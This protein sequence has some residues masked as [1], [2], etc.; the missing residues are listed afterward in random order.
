M[1]QSC[2]ERN[3]VFIFDAGNETRSKEFSKTLK[4]MLP[5]MIKGKLEFEDCHFCRE[6]TQSEGKRKKFEER[7]GF[8]FLHENNRSLEGKTMNTESLE[9]LQMV[10][11][12]CISN[13]IPLVHYTGSGFFDGNNN[14]IGV[15]ESLRW[16]GMDKLHVS[17]P[18]F[19]A[20]FG[21]KLIE[22]WCNE[23][24]N[25]QA[26]ANMVKRFAAA[27]QFFDNPVR[28]FSPCDLIL[29]GCLAL[30]GVNSVPSTVDCNHSES[31]AA[32]FVPRKSLEDIDLTSFFRSCRDDLNEAFT[33][34]S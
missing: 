23:E 21:H 8:V 7:A 5:D 20:N 1:N 33:H 15:D 2:K 34:T 17:Y 6:I 26:V 32:G 25:V 13:N 12:H 10:E 22:S 27:G 24:W 14:P 9:S 28:T 29:Q 16:L 30:C 4:K 19:L 18:Q 3:I 11:R 31:L